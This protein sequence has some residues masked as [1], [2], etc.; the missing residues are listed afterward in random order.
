MGSAKPLDK[1]VDITPP[2]DSNHTPTRTPAHTT[3]AGSFAIGLRNQSS[4]RGRY[5]DRLPPAILYLDGRVLHE[6]RHPIQTWHIA[7]VLHQLALG[8]RVEELDVIG[9]LVERPAAEPAQ[10]DEHE[11][12]AMPPQHGLALLVV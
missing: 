6:Q 10:V 5:G 3:I 8:G 9:V 11:V 7:Q 1:V 2:C 12:A 4:G